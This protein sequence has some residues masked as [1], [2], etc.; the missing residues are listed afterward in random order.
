MVNCVQKAYKQTVIYTLKIPDSDK[1]KSVGIRGKDRP[2][3]WDQD[4]QLIKTEDNLYKVK[5]TYTT[6]YKFTEVKFTV[7]GEYELQNMPNRRVDFNDSRITSYNATFNQE[8][9]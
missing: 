6:G 3:N 5:I 4:T 8:I 9:R 1:I 2:L 7:N